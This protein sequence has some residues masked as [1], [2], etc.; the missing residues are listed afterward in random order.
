MTAARIARPVAVALS[1]AALLAPAATAH[2]LT[3]SAF[4]CGGTGVTSGYCIPQQSVFSF[5]KVKPGSGCSIAVSVVV[6]PT[7]ISGPRG[8]VRIEL[9]RSGAA[10]AKLLA[11]TPRITTG[12]LAGVVFRSLRSGTYTLTGWYEGD[13]VRVASS[14]AHRTFKLSCR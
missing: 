4:S 9:R 13:A 12:G 2:G 8:R 6:R 11:S 5:A 3:R 1:A 10:R 14:H 7:L